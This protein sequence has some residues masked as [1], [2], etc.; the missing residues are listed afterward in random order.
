MRWKALTRHQISSV[1]RAMRDGIIPLRIWDRY[2]F[3]EWNHATAILATDFPE[4]WDDLLKCLGK[5]CL[6]KSSIVV[7]G[8]G[9]SQI[10]MFIDGFLGERGWREHQFNIGIR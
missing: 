1:I 2:R 10:P 3:Q 6:K 4:H 9:R 7:G 8:G 5:F